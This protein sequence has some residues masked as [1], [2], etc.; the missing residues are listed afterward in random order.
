[1]GSNPDRRACSRAVG[2]LGDLEGQV[3][4]PRPAAGQEPGEEVVDLESFGMSTSIRA[5]LAN[6]Q[7]RRGEARA[8][9]ARAPVGAEVDGVPVPDVLP[10]GDGVGHVV[11]HGR[12]RWRLRS[13]PQTGSRPSRCRTAGVSCRDAA[14]DGCGG[15][16]R[17]TVEGMDFRSG[18]GGRTGRAGAQRDG[19]R[20]RSG[21]PRARPD[22]P[23]QSGAQ[24]LCRRRRGRGPGPRP[25][26]SIGRWPPASTRGRW[27]AS[28]SA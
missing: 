1:M 4:G 3:V 28:R 16:A 22:R 13:W 24:R 11:E 9:S 21:R 25:R 20:P 12:R 14:G 8:R 17:R 15:P 23:A 27:P 18:L 7:L 10:T 5:P 2:Q 26:P 19:D 6:W